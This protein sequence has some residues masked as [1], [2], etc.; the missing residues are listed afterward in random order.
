MFKRKR[1]AKVIKRAKHSISR[2]HIDRGALKI[3]YRL[4]DADH[5]AYLVGGCVR[6]LLLGKQPKD[7]D[8]VT[9]ARPQQVKRLFSHAYIIGRRFR[10]VHVYTSRQEFIEVSTFRSG[11]PEFHDSDTEH[12]MIRQD[13]QFGTIEEDVWRR[14]FTINAMYYNIENFAIVDY[15]GGYQDIQ[16]KII[17]IIG[18]PVARFHEDPVRMLRALRF[19]AKRRCVSIKSYWRKCLVHACSMKF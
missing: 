18:D 7:F 19:A 10:L 6:D 13:N 9:E 14:D 3:L 4:K 17:R 16:D 1:K 8:V 11:Q 15:T 5:Q 2:Q 12:A